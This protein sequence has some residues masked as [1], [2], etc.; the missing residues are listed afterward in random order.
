M[1]NTTPTIENNNPARLFSDVNMVPAFTEVNMVPSVEK[2]F[3]TLEKPNK[4]EEYLSFYYSRQAQ[5]SKEAYRKLYLNVY[6]YLSPRLAKDG[7]KLFLILDLFKDR[8]LKYSK[9]FTKIAHGQT[10]CG[11]VSFDTFIRQVRIKRITR[12]KKFPVHVGLSNEHSNADLTLVIDLAEGEP[13]KFFTKVNKKPKKINMQT[14]KPKKRKNKMTQMFVQKAKPFDP[15]LF[16]DTIIWFGVEQEKRILCSIGASGVIYFPK[17]SL[18]K[19]KLTKN[20]IKGIDVGH[21][22]KRDDDF[23]TPAGMYINFHLSDPTTPCAFDINKT[24]MIHIEKYFHWAKDTYDFDLKEYAGAYYAT[25]ISKVNNLL[26]LRL[27]FSTRQ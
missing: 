21:Y 1:S 15:E 17:K 11:R 6:S 24:G 9:R 26:S 27:D 16:E 3:P 18:L 20:D 12:G 5:F 23:N 2:Q 19:L 14:A 4:T 25:V 8:P 13:A 22:T 10:T 7:G